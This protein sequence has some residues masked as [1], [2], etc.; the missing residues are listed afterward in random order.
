MGQGFQSFIASLELEDLEKVAQRA[1]VGAIEMTHATKSSHIGSVLSCIDV[2]TLL[3]SAKKLEE[4]QRGYSSIEVVLSKGHAALA[5]YSVLAELREISSQNLQKYCSNG[6]VLY[7]H[8]D[9]KAHPWI[10]VST[11]SLGHGLPFSVGMALGFIKAKQDRH[12]FCLISDGELNEGTTW[13]SALIGSALG[14]TNISVL[15]DY[16]KIQS[17]GRVDEVLPIE[18]LS[19]KWKSFGWDTKIV[20]GHDFS[21]LRQSVVNITNRTVLILDTIK[22]KGV[23]FMED[24]LEWHYKSPDKEEVSKAISEILKGLD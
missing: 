5:V 15:I 7:G 10:P 13:E 24:K 16:N 1:R 18:P 12:V 2:L 11:G 14:L 3:Y 21:E 9:H 17:F 20:N 23:S 4:I 19:E 22:G 6:Q 8:I